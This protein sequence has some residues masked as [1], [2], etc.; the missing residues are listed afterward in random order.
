MNVGPERRQTP[1]V[2]RTGPNDFVGKIKLERS[3]E[4]A[5]ARARPAIIQ[6]C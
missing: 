1:V 6:R 2:E 3:P 4:I 5:S